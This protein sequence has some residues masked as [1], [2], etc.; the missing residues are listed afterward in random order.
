MHASF[1]A[2]ESSYRWMG[3]HLPPIAGVITEY[4]IDRCR[5]EVMCTYAMADTMVER[6]MQRSQVCGHLTTTAAGK[7]VR[8]LRWTW[9]E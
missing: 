6:G 7:S 9:V 5:T 4:H 8:D 2:S 1:P 3:G